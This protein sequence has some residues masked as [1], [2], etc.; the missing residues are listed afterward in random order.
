MGRNRGVV[1]KGKGN[2]TLQALCR[3]QSMYLPKP[4]HVRVGTCFASKKGSLSEDALK[5]CQMDVESCLYLYNRFAIMPDLTMRLSRQA[6]PTYG[7]KVDIMPESGSAV[8]RV[9]SF[10]GKKWLQ[11][12]PKA[13]VTRGYFSV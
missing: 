10:W 4:E 7:S 6:Y 9:G 8:L 1:R 12:E 3:T 11:I 2:A 5:Y 13:S